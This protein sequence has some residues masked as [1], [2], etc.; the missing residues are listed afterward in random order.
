MKKIVCNLCIVM[1]CGCAR[2]SCAVKLQVIHG[3]VRINSYT[4]GI[5][6]DR[7]IQPGEEIFGTKHPGVTARE[8][9]PACVLTPREHNFHEISCLEGPAVF[10]DILSPPY[11][12]ETGIPN[13]RPRPCTYFR[14]TPDRERESSRG[15]DATLGVKLIAASKPPEFWARSMRYPGPPL[16]CRD[17][18]VSPPLRIS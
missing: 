13:V 17:A 2:K 14:E 4:V 1:R 12:L 18:A 5:S 7:L 10:L 3:A 15:D 9:D 16:R 8:D 6:P 11:V